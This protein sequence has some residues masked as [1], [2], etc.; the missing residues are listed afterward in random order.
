MAGGKK[1]TILIVDDQEINRAILRSILEDMYNI[2]EASNGLEALDALESNGDDINAILL[3]VVMPKMDGYGFMNA[4][5]DTKYDDLP[6]IIL[7][8]SSD[9]EEENK[10]LQLGAWDFITKPYQPQILLSR[11][12]NAIARSQ[13]GLFEQMRQM[14]E[15]DSLTGLYNRTKFYLETRKMID[16]YPDVEFALVR[17]DIDHFS[18]LNAF[19]GEKGGDDLLKDMAKGMEEQAKSFEFCT[20]GRI[21]ADIFCMCVPY[22]KEQLEN[23]L[24]DAHKSISSFRDDYFIKPTFGIYVIDERDMPVESMYEFTAMAAKTCKAQYNTFLAYY[25]KSMRDASYR[26]QEIINDMQHALDT[27]QFVPYLQPKYNLK[28]NSPYGAE[29]LARWIHPDKGMI[30]PGEFIPIFESNG[31]VVKLD[32]YMWDYVCRLL[33]KWIDEGLDPAPV[34]VNISRANMYNPN[35]VSIISDLVASYGLPPYLLNLELTESA[36]MDNPEIMRGVVRG[37]QEKGFTVMMDDF[38]SGYSSLNTLKEISVDVLKIDMKFLMGDDGTGRSER[39]LSSMIRMAGWLNLPVIVEGV[40]T[41]QQVDF[42][43]SVGCGFIQGFF[44][45][46]PMPVSD[47]EQNVVVNDI[48]IEEHIDTTNQ[49]AM[50]EMVWSSDTH[51]E[52]LFSHIKQPVAIYEFEHNECYPLRVN[53]AFNQF[54]GYGENVVKFDQQQSFS[55]IDS[56]NDKIHS[57]FI[58]VC[59]TMATDMCNCEL[60]DQSGK[61]H[62]IHLVLNYLG[63]VENQKVVFAVFNEYQDKVFRIKPSALETD[64]HKMKHEYTKKEFDELVEVLKEEVPIIRVVEPHSER[65]YDIQTLIETPEICHDIWGRCE[66]CDNC[67]SAR[68]LSIKDMA[69]KIEILGDRTYL[70]MSKYVN[71]EGKPLVLE[72]V[73]DSTDGMMLEA[74]KDSEIKEIVDGYNHLLITDSLT[75]IYNRR[76]LDEHFIPSLECCYHGGITINVAMM[77]IDDFKSINDKYGHQAGDLLLKDIGG[78]WKLHFDSRIRGKERLAIRYGG[79]EILIIGSSMSKEEFKKRI[80]NLYA[81]MRK[82]CYCSNNVYFPFSISFG[83]AS[84]EDMNENWEWDELLNKADEEMYKNKKKEFK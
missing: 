45:A 12:R 70:I 9:V 77:D 41:K 71:I 11:L 33:K 25:D 55:L 83:F 28:T 16:D 42:L 64:E 79:D 5:K 39:I 54:F 43:R 7:T 3:D 61:T 56:T 44:F 59:E 49:V 18:L 50:S 40:E 2:L 14:A 8:A 26:E 30:S 75:G 62:T 47:Y 48:G 21:N 80:E 60:E 65:V 4:I 1:Q 37:L 22:D 34:S 84:S 35:I 36:Y 13:M 72:M 20:Y 68:A 58:R 76:F 69:M 17:T 10:A 66:R 67:T 78:F 46:R 29:A 6:I 15:F 73:H 23:A 74:H 51:I 53:E 24:E 63:E 27:G 19:W 82:T 81:Q 57:L 31:F 32:Y 52:F 38:G